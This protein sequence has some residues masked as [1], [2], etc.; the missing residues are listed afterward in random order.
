[1]ALAKIIEITSESQ[2]SYDDA[3]TRGIEDA[4]KTVDNIRSAWVKD[5]EVL[6]GAGDARTHRV[7]LKITFLVDESRRHE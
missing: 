2:K 7:S 1:M 6:V 4:G 5:H 3:V